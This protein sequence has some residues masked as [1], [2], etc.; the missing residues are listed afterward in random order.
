MLFAPFG[1]IAHLLHDNL[2]FLFVRPDEL[3]QTTHVVSA[4]KF[5]LGVF[6]DIVIVIAEEPTTGIILLVVVVLVRA[7]LTS[8]RRVPSGE[9]AFRAT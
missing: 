3:L 9:P 8:H 1:E 5:A 2:L 7:I 4:T 6:I